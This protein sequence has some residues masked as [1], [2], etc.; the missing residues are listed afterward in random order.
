[1]IGMNLAQTKSGF[2]DRPKVQRAM[3]RAT[4]RVHSKFGA[5]VRTRA[6]SSIRKRKRVSE[7]GMPP[8][9]HTGLLKKFIFFAWDQQRKSVV[10]GPAKLNKPANLK[11]LEEG[12]KT[13]RETA[14]GPRPITIQARPFMRPAFEAEKP[15]LSRLW[16]N[17]VR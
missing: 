15:M 12:G 13:V 7:P 5:F 17:S 9:G 11:A 10:I 3:D 8:S 14:K 1:M 4:A 2:F 6:R 16:A